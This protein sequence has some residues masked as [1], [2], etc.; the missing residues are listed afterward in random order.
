[1]AAPTFLVI[2]A[3]KAGTTSLH[4]YLAAHP[5]VFAA[6]D[7]ELNFFVEEL[8]WSRGWSWYEAQF[9]D[10]GSALAV[11]ESSPSY[12]S[13]PWRQGVPERI[14][15]ALPDVRLIYLL[16]HP[17][18]R[19]QSQYFHR[20]VKEE[21]RPPEEAVFDD[22]YLGKSLYAQQVQC[23]LEYFDRGNLL[24]V[25]SEDLSERRVETMARVFSFVGVNPEWRGEVLGQEYHRTQAKLVDWRRQESQA[26]RRWR[27]WLSRSSHQ[28]PMVFSDKLTAELTER[29]ADDQHALRA[30]A[31][32]LVERW[33]LI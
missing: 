30:L 17:V 20:A 21:R 4:R 22:R 33:S 23:Y 26:K 6:P 1:V 12:S 11:G 28:S 32:E 29:L 2:G 3:M 25:G 24:L 18:D 7:K 27:S 10:A 8:N 9:S 31:P 13:Y 16:R 14:A 19:L 15:A 5:Q